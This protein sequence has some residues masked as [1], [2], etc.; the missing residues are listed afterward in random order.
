MAALRA[1]RAR[2]ALLSLA[3]VGLAGAVGTSVWQRGDGE[4]RYT[5]DGQMMTVGE[6]AGKRSITIEDVENLAKQRSLTPDQVCT[7]P[8]KRLERAIWRLAN[9]KPS[10]PSEALRWRQLAEQ[11]ETGTIAPNGR[12]D[13]AMQLASMIERQSQR[14][15]APATAGLERANWRWLGPGNIGGRTR[16]ILIHPTD[17]NKMWL[18]SV[19]GGIWRTTNGGTSWAP[20]NNFLS[21]MAVSTMAMHPTN[22]SIMYAGTGEGFYNGDGI[23]GAGILKSTNGGTVWTQLA[24]TNSSFFHY[25]NRLAISPDGNTILAATRAGLFRSTD[26][27]ATFNL[28]LSLDALDVK[29]HPTD[30]TKAVASGY[31]STSV[32]YST[33]G[34]VTWTGATGIP[35]ASFPRIELA[36]A[37]SDGTIVYASVD[38]GGGKVYKSTNSGQTYTLQTSGSP[39][40]LGSQG[41]YDNVIWVSPTDPNLVVVGGIDLWRSTNG[42]VNLTKISQWF[43]APLSAHADHHVIV[44]HPGYNGTT[45]K[46]VFFGNDGGIYRANDVTTVSL[47][48]GWQ[49]LLNNLGIT[50]FYGAAGNPRTGEVIGGTQDNGTLH[51]SR[52]KGPQGW[53]APFG[54]DGGWSAA[55]PTNANYFYGEYVYLTI[56]RSSNR[57]VSSSFIYSGISDANACANFIAPFILDPNN[58][59]RMLAGGCSLWRS[60]NVKAPT[61]TWASIKPTIG[62]EIS[63]IV[64]APGNSDVVYVGHNNGNIYKTT[65]GTASPP[66]W[67]QIDGTLPNRYVTRLT[68]DWTDPNIVYATFGGYTTPN[69]YKSVNGGTS[70]TAIGGSG[71][72]VLPSAPVRSLLVSQYNANWLYVGTEVGIFTSEDGGLNWHVPHD[73]PTNTSVDELQWMNSALL[74]ATHGRGI[75]KGETQPCMTLTININPAANGTVL[76]NPRPNCVTDATKYSR[77]TKVTLYATPAAGK[78]F[79]SWTGAVGT[80]SIGRVN[81]L[82]NRTVTANFSP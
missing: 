4:P 42:G 32:Y 13:A 55:D 31:S 49:H 47:T 35:V 27:G 20:V 81:M 23:R 17:P 50:Q 18:G 39:S 40:Y 58:A 2:P 77:G 43:S 53:T 57:G 22:P 67:T 38:T 78:S 66:T 61:P 79:V 56:H 70:W 16:S 51:Y 1:L 60:N 54:G 36:F 28:Q 8:Q 76:A 71:A 34:G 46:T 30:S 37:P 3:V 45:N 21:N 52:A 24:S 33:N 25:V 10:N 41:W 62:S 29:F 6:I 82:G 75:W 68:V 11:D 65:N 26:A 14:G 59:D 69:V 64:V 44:H 48:S 63:A 73:G 72:N 80:T 19:A 15:V 9:P 12:I 7:I 5:C 74:A